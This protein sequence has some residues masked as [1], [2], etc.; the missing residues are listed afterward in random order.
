MDLFLIFKKHLCS[1][2]LHF[3]LEKFDLKIEHVF[4]NI[5][6]ELTVNDFMIEYL[7]SPYKNSYHKWKKIPPTSTNEHINVILVLLCACLFVPAWQISPFLYRIT[8]VP[9]PTTTG[10]DCIYPMLKDPPWVD[11]WHPPTG[12]PKI[13]TILILWF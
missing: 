4:K 2:W 13:N 9:S 3:Y 7:H 12:P 5:L 10:L 11:T 8:K 6:Q 1:F